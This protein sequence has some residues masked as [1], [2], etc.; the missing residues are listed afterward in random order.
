MYCIDGTIKAAD[1]IEYT[2]DHLRKVK[3]RM[4]IRNGGMPEYC[5]IL[6]PQA[7]DYTI[8]EICSIEYST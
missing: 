1:N 8:G 6:R 4:G 5:A 3:A 2:I 7:I